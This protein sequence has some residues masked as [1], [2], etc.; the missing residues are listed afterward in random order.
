[1]FGNFDEAWAVDFEYAVSP[2]ERPQPRCL[3]ALELHSGRR[4]RLWKDELRRL[5]APPYDTGPRTLFIAYYASAEVA[6]HLALGWPP[7]ARVL[8]LYAEFRN[9]TNGRRL[10]CGAG[11]I[12]ALTH[13][14]L[15]AIGAAEK[16]VMRDLALRGGHY[17]REE[18]LDLLDY[19]ETDVRALEKLLPC[20]APGISLPHALMRGRYMVAAARIEHAGTPVD[21]AALE[22]LRSNW[23]QVKGHIVQRMDR[24]FGVFDGTVFK[25]TRWARWLAA[26]DIPWPLLE[27]G[28]PALDDDTFR[29]MARAHP[30]VAPIRELRQ[31]L[32]RMRLA[33]LA[34]GGDGRNRCML[35]AFR[36]RTGRNQPSNSR[37][38]FGPSTWLRGLIR[39]QPGCGLAYVDYEQQEFAIAAALSGD[40][41]MVEAYRSGDPY[42]AFAMQA[43]AVPEDATKVSHAKEREQFK[44]CAL[45][46]QYGMAPESLGQRI[47]LT[48]AHGRDLLE[49]HHQTY[50][51][52]WRWSDAVVDHAMLHNRLW[53]VFGWQLQISGAANHR[54]LRNFPVQ[55]NGAEMLRL[56]CCLATERGIRVCAPV[57]DALLIEAPLRQLDSAV[58]MTRAA[59]EEASELVLDG[60]T[61]GTDVKLVMYP[62]RYTDVRGEKMWHTVWEAIADLEARPPVDTPPVHP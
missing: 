24:G 39:P 58:V 30:A 32:S 59:M 55:G 25:A 1:M 48:T 47:G 28:R 38:I 35:S 60:F 5:G 4:L 15:D 42:L 37:F 61:V 16:D 53:T 27:S 22:S 6:C 45:A 23:E 43:G 50:P 12:G 20:M 19:C 9:L 40:Q 3:V 34:V 56:A 26:H 49:R 21:V 11:L 52:F 62:D 33:D 41:R 46:V 54:S 8:D 18:R 51:V 36:A 14:G 7:P 29:A 10:P 17:T 44:A 31:A 2:G 57:H 13:F